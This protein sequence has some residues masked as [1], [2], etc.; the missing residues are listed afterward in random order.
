[1]N[2]KQYQSDLLLCIREKKLI[3]SYRPRL[4][5]TNYDQ[6]ISI[7]I[8]AERSVNFTEDFCS[9]V[10]HL[11]TSYLTAGPSP[12]QARLLPSKFLRN[13]PS[14]HTIT[15]DSIKIKLSRYRHAGAKGERNYSSYSIFT[16]AL[17]GVSGQRH[18]PAAFY[19][20]EKTPVTTG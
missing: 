20:R 7:Q 19:P 8:S 15:L 17:E 14:L 1:M 18:A 5:Q 9:L 12:G 16:S 10:Q 6:L 11:H 4:S 3:K 2:T 13:V